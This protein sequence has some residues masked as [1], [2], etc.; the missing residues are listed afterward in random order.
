MYRKIA[1]LIISGVFL[2]FLFG[3]GGD[4]LTG[5]KLSNDPNRP[6]D[7]PLD[8]L[9][10]A[11]QVNA[12]GVVVGPLSFIPVMWLQQMS[13]V[14]QHWSSYEVYEITGQQFDAPWFDIYGG[15]GLADIKIIKER[16]QAQEKFI[17]L[18]IAKMWEALLINTAADLW[19]DVPYSE[20][21]N[22]DQFPTPKY[23]KQSEVAQ[24]ALNLI[25]EA[26]ADFQK[27]QAFFDGTL[28]FTYGGDTE[29][30]I[31]AA[32]S[33]KARILLNWAEV[34]PENYQLALNEAQQG[35]ASE[36]DNW[37]AKFSETSGEENLWYQFEARRFGYVK[38]ANFIVELLKKD[39]DP[40]LEIYFGKD[41]DGNYSGSKPG[42]N[43]GSASWLNTETF[44]S[45]DWD[46]E[47]LTWAET[48]FII[49]ECQYAL[50]DEDAARN[51]LNNVIQPGLEAK[52]GLEPNSLP[53]Y[54]TQSGV[55]LLEAIMLEKYKA[56]FLNL[57]IWSDWKRTAFPILPSTPQGRRIPR[58]MLYPESELNTNPNAKFLG[59][60][61][62]TEN[63]PGNPQYPGRTVNP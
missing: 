47:I 12:Y 41:I 48:Q 55:D 61:A 57:Q 40:R 22:P 10:V 23:D 28:D 34:K 39:N 37:T 43:N 25:D 15:G 63:D 45:K 5:G 35:I 29:K 42:E 36:A 1:I 21:V 16:A 13:G 19:G 53:R 32:H 27:G 14:S 62:R 30:W 52:W 3:C 60:Y 24:A 4:F 49:A 20:A 2:S 58:R 59:L 9:V 56:L 11:M 33:L 18:G 51:T 26:I 46:S 6:T 38:A 7:V 50:G 31:R 54:E 17:T 44:G 8:N